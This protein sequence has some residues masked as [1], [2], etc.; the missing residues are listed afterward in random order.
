MAYNAGTAFLQVIPSF[1]NIEKNIAGELRKV[2]RQFASELEKSLPQSFS[3][4]VAKASKSM[5]KD[6][7]KAAQDLGN[8]RAKV[9]GQTLAKEESL[10]KQAVARELKRQGDLANGIE[11]IRRKR[12]EQEYRDFNAMKSAEAKAIK[13]DEN[14]R[15]AQEE[16]SRQAR[17][18]T[19]VKI[20]E[21]RERAISKLATDALR[22]RDRQR[23][24]QIRDDERAAEQRIATARRE[25]QEKTN[26]ARKQYEEQAKLEAQE[27]ARTTAGKAQQGVRNSATSIQDLPVHLNEN[28]IYGEMQRIR[29]KIKSL[30][31]VEIGVDISVNDFIGQVEAQ[32]A[33]L[34]MI[35]KDTSVDID[36]RTDAAAAA[37]E[38]G[39]VLVLLGRIDG[40]DSH[41]N[42]DIDTV[43]A[44]QRLAEFGQS[45]EVNFSRLGQLIALGASLGS[46]IVPAAAAA[47][48]AIGAIGTAALAAGAGVGVLV[49]GFGGIGDAIKALAQA[50]D[51]QEK[52]NKSLTNSQKQV[53][54]AVDAVTS[55]R[56]SLAN[57]IANNR[58]AAI[59]ADQAVADAARDLAQARK[60][61]DRDAADAA[62][63]LAKARRDAARDEE[64]AARK[65]ADARERAAQ[66][67][68]DAARRTADAQR[69]LTRSEETAREARE[70][71]TQAYKDAQKSLEDLASAMKHNSLDQQ[72]ALLDI[73]EAKEE[74]DKLIANPRATDAER[75]QARIN[76]EKR[77]LEL[78]DLSDTQRQNQQD[79]DD[80]IKDGLKGSKEVVEAQKRIRDAEQAVADA[81][82]DLADAQKSQA[83]AIIDGQ[84]N[85]ADAIRDQQ[86]SQQRGTEAIADAIR[87][88]QEQQERSARAISD[89]EQ[90]LANERRDREAQ[91][92]QAAFSLANAQ[93]GVV[94]AQRALGAAT[95]A[96]AA[97]GGAA[98]DNLN[99]AMGK[100]SPTA[101]NFAKFIYGLKDEFYDLRSAAADSFLPGLQTAIES[102]LPYLPQVRDFVKKVG[103]KLGDLFVDFAD[104]LK[105]PVFQDFFG[106]IDESAVPALDDLYTITTNLIEGFLGLFLGFTPLSDDVSGGLVEM[107]E[108]FKDWATSLDTNDGF[109]KFMDYIRDN[110]PLVVEF[111]GSLIKFGGKLLEAMAPLGPVILVILDAIVDFLSNIPQDTLIALVAGIAGMAAALGV[112][113]AAT[114]IAAIS[115]TAFVIAGVVAA[116]AAAVVAVVI[117]FNK[118]EPLRTFFKDLWDSVVAAFDSF[119][120]A[121]QPTIQKIGDTAKQLYEGFI[122]PAFHGI[123]DVIQNVYAI[124]KPVFDLFVFVLGL[125]GKAAIFLVQ[126]VWTP[127]IGSMVGPIVNGV[128]PVVKFLYFNV[129]K[130]LF[131]AIQVAVNILAAVFKVAFG[132]VQIAFKILGAVFSGFYNGFVKPWLDPL[133]DAVKTVGGAIGKFITPYWEKALKK[134]GE[135]WETLRKATSVPIRFIVETLLNDGI[136]KGYNK[137][138]EFFDVE[139]KNV[140]IPPPKAGWKTGGTVDVLPG[141]SP[142][143]DDH[144]FV[145]PTGGVIGLSG[146][147]GILRPEVTALVKPW[148]NA[149]NAAARSGGKTGAQKFLGGF[150]RG[151]VVPGGGDGLGDLL[152]ST[153]SAAGKFWEKLKDKSTD[154]F[155]GIKD[156][157]S[158]PTGYLKRIAEKLTNLVPG[159]DTTFIKAALG[160]P[161][162]VV[163]TLGDKVKSLISPAQDEGVGNG[164]PGSAGG[165]GG[166]AGMMKILRQVFPGLPLISGY[167]PGAITATGHPS[168][169]GKNRATDLPPRMDVFQWLRKNYP[170]SREIIFSPAGMQQVWN[171]RP[172]MYSGITRQMHFNHVHWAYDQ[173]GWLPDTRQM[174]NQTMPIFHGRRQPDAVLTNEQWSSISQV[175]RQSMGGGTGRSDTYNFDFQNSTLTADRL[176]A[177][178]TRRDTL[179]RVSRP[180]R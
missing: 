67:A 62:R 15:S 24:Q 13:D 153:K 104:S 116:I 171:G 23:E 74:L 132:L 178:Q 78:E 119:A 135:F 38:L 105:D 166:S 90:R 115:T 79:Y 57:T 21:A 5:E 156:F 110:G 161:K 17:A 39:S 93:D 128:V 51:D 120:A 136:L 158:D 40:K 123:V 8:A 126:K 3:D 139:P 75:E 138:A 160:L 134:L 172:H 114:T 97:A 22:E 167:R 121:I 159:K 155:E 66:D 20:A 95:V 149:A 102:L 106:Y 82:R 85:V 63:R 140:Q 48:G 175:A 50:E 141:Y 89:A 146:G 179:D 165:L 35:A 59:K 76:Y 98:M 80:Q 14:T 47:A 42:V 6:A 147:E 88:Q 32:F 144:T 9:L 7:T 27:L 53:A 130:P 164:T 73:A 169:H 16:A 52:T 111:F 92:R 60:D 19:A 122:V 125:I 107:T 124:L 137:L 2:A 118:Y 72:Q 45:L 148:L 100:L 65:V 41:A 69:A 71:L 11:I 36:V 109:Q 43:S 83:K 28:N 162:K 33:R 68:E 163:T 49:L 56:R 108:S 170:N 168:Y 86:E 151:G 96:S 99:T 12:A 64:E 1:E 142:G 70:K 91:Q 84:R 180:N 61:A 30:G 46:V 34:R 31:D 143:V 77:K 113:S 101:Q 133:M 18:N 55:A 44:K 154:V 29:E 4:A 173:G 145:S 112:L 81:R 127:Y 25:A 152:N 26:S 176:S 177:I 129:I 131:A 87:S 157:V 174:P 94:Q 150:S 58:D 103:T 37:T 10:Q 54:N 117:L